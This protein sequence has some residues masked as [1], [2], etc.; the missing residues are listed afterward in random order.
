MRTV[1]VQGGWRMWALLIVG[2]VTLLVLGLTVGLIMLGVLAVAGV[3]LLGQ[4]ALQAIELG[5]R[6]RQADATAV[7]EGGIIDGEFRVMSCS[8]G[9][10]SNPLADPDR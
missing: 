4:R 7:P 2:G 6:R 9:V 10:A 1:V 3:L 5:R 8:T